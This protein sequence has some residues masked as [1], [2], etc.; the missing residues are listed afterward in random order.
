MTNARINN[1][2]KLAKI[3]NILGW[4]RAKKEC[5]ERKEKA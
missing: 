1:T 5:V 4:N 3:H 2:K